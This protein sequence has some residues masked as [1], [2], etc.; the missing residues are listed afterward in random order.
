MLANKAMLAIHLGQKTATN[1]TGYALHETEAIKHVASNNEKCVPYDN[2]VAYDISE[3]LGEVAFSNAS[4]NMYDENQKSKSQVDTFQDN[5]LSHDLINS[6]D[7]MMLPNDETNVVN[8]I[9]L[10][11]SNVIPK[12]Q[13]KMAIKEDVIESNQL[14]SDIV[15]QIM[16]L[17]NKSEIHN[18][19]SWSGWQ[20]ADGLREESKTL[21]E[22]L[23]D[24]RRKVFH[25]CLAGFAD[26]ANLLKDKKTTLCSDLHI[27]IINQLISAGFTDAE[28]RDSETG[29]KPQYFTYEPQHLDEL[30][31]GFC[32]LRNELEDNIKRVCNSLKPFGQSAANLRLNTKKKKWAT[33][34]E[35]LSYEASISTMMWEISD[36]V[37]R[38]ILIS[39]RLL[40][41]VGIEEGLSYDEFKII[42]HKFKYEFARWG[43][44]ESNFE[45]GAMFN[46]LLHQH[47][48][49]GVTGINYRITQKSAGYMRYDYRMLD[50]SGNLKKYPILKAIVELKDAGGGDL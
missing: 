39:L 37:A 10:E 7:E 14:I 19:C 50:A 22:K 40:E 32:R 3:S 45:E 12:I 13:F 21:Y 24:C 25:S 29:Y 30:A 15:K 26:A 41:E 48:T 11:S 23:E 38:N 42:Q 4:M 16:E 33:L 9:E 28:L 20:V 1:Y 49:H 18:L 8:D 44:V 5:K 34:T 35:L 17:V 47:L 46:P 2:N 27:S 36:K 43:V 6:L 31:R